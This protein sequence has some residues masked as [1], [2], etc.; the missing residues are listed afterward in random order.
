M[1][2]LHFCKNKLFCK[3]ATLFRVKILHFYIFFE[4][5]D[6]FKEKNRDTLAKCLCH[7][8]TKYIISNQGLMLQEPPHR[9]RA[10]KILG[11]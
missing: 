6:I 4:Y 8:L 1:A 3:S 5:T 9:H 10:K 7:I 11:P 2:K